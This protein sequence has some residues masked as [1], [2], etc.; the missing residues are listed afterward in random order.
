[1]KFKSARQAIHDAYAIHMKS[2]G[3]EANLVAAVSELDASAEQAKMQRQLDRLQGKELT[4][5]QTLKKQQ[6]VERINNFAPVTFAHGDRSSKVD[7]DRLIA[8][9]TDAA[10]VIAIVE[11][12][13]PHLK[14]WCYWC[15]S[16]LGDGNQDWFKRTEMESKIRRCREEADQLT[17]MV[18]SLP[19][20][21][22]RC[23]TDKRRAELEAIDTDRA[24]E[25]SADLEILADRHERQLNCNNPCAALWN[26]LDEQIA[27]AAPEKMRKK[28]ALHVRDVCRATFYNYRYQVI[29]GTQK[30]LLARRDICEKF[31]VPADS[32]ENTYRPWI[33]WT[34]DLCDG[35]DR[36]GL[37]P[38]GAVI[39]K[40]ERAI[41]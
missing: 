15:Y 7:P 10:K 22:A 12:L 1:M 9:A 2:K 33:N 25:L 32:F 4:Q 13:P 40:D 35:L 18:V 14:T 36:E 31:G 27:A 17:D 20:R 6:L 39:R 38:L 21:I 8:D 23:K 24:L 28:T 34:N 30:Q 29:T 5:L 19:A 37:R 26:W 16:P 3:F 41:A 11:S